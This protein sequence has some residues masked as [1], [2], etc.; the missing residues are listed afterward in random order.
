MPASLEEIE[1]AYRSAQMFG[2]LSATAIEGC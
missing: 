1:L 2:K